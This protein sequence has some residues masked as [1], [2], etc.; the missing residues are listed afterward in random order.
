MSSSVQ[1]QNASAQPYPLQR[2]VG[3]AARRYRVFLSYSHAETKW[4]TWLMRRLEAYRVPGRLQGRAAPIGT[5]GPRIAPVFRDRDELPSASDL[6]E[7]IRTALGESATL[8]VIC[9]PSAAKSRWVKDEILTFKRMHG[10]AGVFAFIVA[11]EPKREGA[12]DDCFSPAL[13][14]LLGPDGQP[15]GAPA[16]VVAADARPHAD[17][18]ELAFIRLVAGL[19]GVGFDDL[20]QRELQRRYRRMTYISSASVLGMA[21]TLGLAAL[22]WQGRNDARRRQE[23]AEDLLGFMLG[24]LRTQL[25]RVGRLDVLETV[26]DKAVAYF[27]GLDSRD[28][29]D[30]TLTNLAKAHTQI[31]SVRI[32]QTQYPE[33]ARA[34]RAAYERTAALAARHPENGTIL[35]ERAQAEWGIGNLHY[36]RGDMAPA[37]EWLTRY[38]DTTVDLAKL[39]PA[40]AQWQREAVSGYHNLAVLDL[41]RADLPAARRGF[42]WELEALD[43]ILAAE[44]RN[45]Q[46]HFSRANVISFLGT[47]AERSGDY[48][49]AIARFAGQVQTLENLVR[50]DPGTAR[51]KDRLANALALQA[52]V[53]GITGRRAEAVALRSRSRELLAPFLKQDAS[54]RALQSAAYKLGLDDAWVLRAKGDLGG[55]QRRLDEARGGFE[56]L[57]RIEA[58][59]RK[60]AGLLAAAWRLEAQLRLTAKRDDV[61]P[62]ISQ[63]LTLGEDLIARERANDTFAGDYA[64]ACV[65]AGTLAAQSGTQE[66]ATRHWQRALEVV[67]SRRAETADWRLLDPLA[68]ALACLGQVEES[69][70]VIAKLHGFGYQPLEPWP[71]VSGAG[72]SG[73]PKDAAPR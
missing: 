10:E 54:N 49:E 2:G 53:L 39:D 67:R 64:N 56:R 3:A 43:R 9:S 70:A 63:A 51:W 31:A 55:A 66:R 68:R 61:E 8:V 36:L 22:A 45:W 30:A 60:V 5:V 35:F 44:P 7:T 47:V 65:V 12:E 15:S 37:T 1:S 26:G 69:R 20:R 42:V 6:G 18:R 29:T 13:R 73:A 17:G 25:E 14:R 72:P 59:D 28:L 34:F 57:A 46:L 33:A 21:I 32:K 16:E 27:A 50:D 23:Q 62:A 58:T 24:D 11:G 71:A 38:R 41:E 52:G 40:N 48:G 19:V 4:A